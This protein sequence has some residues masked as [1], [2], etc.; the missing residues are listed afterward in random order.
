[1]KILNSFAKIDLKNLM[2]Y[3]LKK[4]CFKI[5][6]QMVAIV[7]C[8]MALVTGIFFEVS[9]IYF[10]SMCVTAV[11]SFV[12]LIFIRTDK[13]Y[14]IFSI[15]YICYLHFVLLPIFIIWGPKTSESTPLCFTA[16]IVATFFVLALKDSLIIFF[17]SFYVNTFLV[18]RFFVNGDID[19][20]ISK[21]LD[22]FI[23]FV[24][25]FI[26][27]AMALAFVIYLQERNFRSYQNAVDN[28][29]DAEKRA[30]AAKSRFLAN[31]SHEIRTPMNSI[32]GLSELILKEDMNDVT[33][34]EV[35]VVKQSSYELLDIIDD[36][37]MYSKLESEK[38][39]LVASDFKFDELLR[40]VVDS[41]SAAMTN[42]DLK[43]RV[44][45]DNNIPK[46][47]RGDDVH[48]KQVLLRL[49]FIS[50]SLTE[51]GRIMMSLS[52]DIDEE[53]G[54][55]HMTGTVSDTGCG[56]AQVDLDAIYGAY[57]VYDSRQNSNFK[58][59]ALKFNICN[60]LLKLMNGDLTINSIDGMGLESRFSF[61]C[62]VVNSEPM[63]SMENAYQKKILIYINDNR[64]L[65]AWKAVM[66][67]FSI[68]PDYVNSYFAFEKAVQNVKYDYIFL[69]SE[70]YSSVSNVIAMYHCEENTYV[71]G[72]SNNSYG[73][74]DKCR[75]IRHP[76]SCLNIGDV[77]N[78]LW[79][80]EDYVIKNEAEEYDGRKARIL[81]VDDNGV[82]LKVATGI[83]K[84]YKIDIDVAKSG[85][86]AIRKMTMSEYHL[87][88]MD[89]V[90]PEMSGSEAL[91]R[92]RNS[93]I[94]S[95]MNVPIVALTANTG[96]NIREEVLELGFQEYLAKPIKQR[97]LTQILTGFLPQDVFKKILKGSKSSE[98]AS[99]I[100]MADNILE[101]DKGI[102][103]IGNN[104]EAYHAILNTYYAEGLRKIKE[105]PDLLE[106]GDISL[107]TTHVHGIK[108]SS[109]SIG[110]ATVSLMFKELEFAGKDNNLELIKARYDNYIEAF[111]KIL[112]DVKEY[113]TNLGKFDY[114][115]EESQE[116]KEEQ[117]ITVITDEMFKE[118]KGYL[119]TMNLKESDKIMA[120]Y[121]KMNFG[122]EKNEIFAK[123]KKS[124][125]MYDFH[126]VK[127]LLNLMIG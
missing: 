59:I 69:T 30:S 47:V 89:M 10:G 33:R 99:E 126:E 79:K 117:E 46:I 93:G 124:Y 113:L 54:V 14:R 25:V 15:L 34:N 37:L 74:F 98:K 90:M 28:A 78:G 80:T 31:M 88:L 127:Q 95:M 108:S 81:V 101:P 82:N 38:L 51:N 1:M 4:D 115:E 48:I 119:D 103:N 122:H 109:A 91:T 102:A 96:G 106:A 11:L 35:D 76:V 70:L 2:N 67:G 65:A 61:D 49:L 13:N 97:Y 77:I 73:D 50:L 6:L 60:S 64:E 9:A 21:P 39:K 92:I 107:F 23:N 57:D 86:E 62:D 55:A 105:L 125:D 121:S 72:Y 24:I 110:A 100:N 116:S 123:L 36:V 45:F 63:V 5:V 66:E 7:S 12:M 84:N 41:I 42:K 32:I 17:F 19:A 20:E 111:K 94:P 18:I 29:Q 43:L 85:E 27:I 52:C 40:Q 83:F 58:G 3:D 114:V 71:A 120:S 118:F 87:V 68:R 22:F 112:D 53:N 16:A 8:L 44:K 26:G 56:L 75:I 104:A